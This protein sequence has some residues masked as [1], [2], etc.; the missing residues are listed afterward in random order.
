MHA[1]H[2]LEPEARRCDHIAEPLGAH[3]VQHNLRALRAFVR[4][5][6]LAAVEFRPGVAQY[7]PF[8]E[9]RDHAP[10][11][12]ASRPKSPKKNAAIFHAA[13]KSKQLL[14]FTSTLTS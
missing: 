2:R 7:V 12:S 6:E 8:R 13:L 11:S 14:E 4:R 1:Q 5:H 9:H 3:P 10:P